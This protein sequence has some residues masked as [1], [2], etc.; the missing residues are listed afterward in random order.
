MRGSGLGLVMVNK[1]PVGATIVRAWRFVVR[2]FFNILGISAPVIVLSWIP[3]LLIYGPGA[4]SDTGRVAHLMPMLLPLYLATFLALPMQLIGIAQ[5][6]MGAKT[7]PRWLYLSLGWP[8]W[9]LAGSILF[10]MVVIALL[11]LGAVLGFAL[12]AILVKLVLGSVSASWAGALRDALLLVGGVAL[13][14]TWIYATARLMFLLIPVIAAREPGFAL[15]RGWT[16]GASNVWRIFVLLLTAWLPLILL[17]VV[18]IGS[19]FMGVH[20]PPPHAS[21]EQLAA[22]QTAL[23]AHMQQFTGS[24][25]HYWYATMPLSMAVIVLFHGF[26][27]ACQVFAYEAVKDSPPVA[28]DALP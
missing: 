5:L 16:L 10:F 28:G 23:D 27:V 14:G 11:A 20:F 6:A 18:V 19:L 21:P 12:L 26:T 2:E 15:A 24:L 1:I 7:A 3:N 8:I 9:R 17:E 22:F 25:I 4:G 13:W